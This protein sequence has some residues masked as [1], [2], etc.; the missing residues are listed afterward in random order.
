MHRHFGWD[1]T[2]M[3]LVRRFVTYSPGTPPKENKF[4]QTTGVRFA[5][6]AFTPASSDFADTSRKMDTIAA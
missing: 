5:I 1:F 3:A 6:D 2:N 4:P